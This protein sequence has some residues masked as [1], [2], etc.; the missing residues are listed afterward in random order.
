MDKNKKNPFHF[1]VP[2]AN[3]QYAGLLLILAESFNIFSKQR[4]LID[5]IL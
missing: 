2:A 1:D 5:S 4:D 3:W